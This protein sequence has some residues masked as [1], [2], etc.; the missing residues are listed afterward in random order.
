MQSYKP[1][2]HRF[3]EEQKA[4]GSEEKRVN[5]VVNGAAKA[6]PNKARKLAGIFISDDITNVKSYILNDV[7]LPSLK[8]AVL[9]AIDM[10]LPGGSVGYNKRSSESKVSYRKYYD[11]PGDR[12]RVSNV[13]RDRFD[14]DDI[15]FETRGDAE[16]ALDEMHAIL[17]HYKIVRVADLYDIAQ[18]S[19][20]YTSNRYGWTNLRSAEIIRAGGGYIIRLPRALPID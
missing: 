1:N 17:D 11:E 18:L 16:L 7:L 5:H 15:I 13:Q 6:K 9:G 14:H 4:A 10:A 2:S 3:K 12:Q 20:P 8:K 19:Q